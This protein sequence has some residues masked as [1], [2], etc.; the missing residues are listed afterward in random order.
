M[1]N[2]SNTSSTSSPS[3]STNA[4]DI[5]VHRFSIREAVQCFMYGITHN[6]AEVAA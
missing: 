5:S 1:T 4:K 6:Q 2:S 3:L